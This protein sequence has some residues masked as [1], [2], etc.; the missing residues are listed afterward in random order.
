MAG[1]NPI[2]N[3]APSS[4]AANYLVFGNV[5]PESTKGSEP[6]KPGGGQTPFSNKNA[7]GKP[8]LPTTFQDGLVPKNNPLTDPSAVGPAV[9]GQA[10]ISFQVQ[11]NA[12]GGCNPCLPAT[13]HSAMNAAMAD[14]SVRSLTA[15]MDRKL[16]WPT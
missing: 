5:Y 15:G 14:G 7:Q 1:V 2:T 8:V 9:S 13:G 10:G 16:W 3:Y 6:S 12:Q 4:Y 11:P